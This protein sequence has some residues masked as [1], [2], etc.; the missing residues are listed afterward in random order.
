M[1]TN[2]TVLVIANGAA[3]TSD[4]DVIDIKEGQEPSVAFVQFREA[5]TSFAAELAKLVVRD[6]ELPQP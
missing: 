1:S 3:A 6:V 5:L 4:S 2:D